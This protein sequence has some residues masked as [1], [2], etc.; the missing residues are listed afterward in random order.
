MTTHIIV[1]K[2]SSL[3]P[4]EALEVL[5]TMGNVVSLLV[6]RPHDE[7]FR[8]LSPPTAEP[9]IP[10]MRS[11]FNF[12]HQQ[13]MT[14]LESILPPGVSWFA[15]FF[16][17]FTR[18]LM[19]TNFYAIFFSSSHRLGVWNNACETAGLIGFHAAERGWGGSG[20]LCA[21]ACSRACNERW[22]DMRWWQNHRG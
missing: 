11:S 18:L 12:K 14:Q 13:Y 17:S 21:S 22:K 16:S 1:N 20:T 6:C 5:R 3:H 4:Q 15:Y 9:P 19:M 8:K 2:F 10:P 7:N